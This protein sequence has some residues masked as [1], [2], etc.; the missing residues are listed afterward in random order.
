MK[1]VQKKLADLRPH[2]RNVRRHNQNQVQ[3]LAKAVE[4]FGQ[5][6]PIVCDETGTILCGHGLFEAMKLNGADK[7]DCI[8][9]TG[10]TE[11]QKTKL[12]L[13]D[14]KIYDLGTSDYGVIDEMLR[15]FG[16]EGDFSIPGYDPNVLEDLY[17]I[18]SVEQSA[19]E[20]QSMR[21][22]APPE[23]SVAPPTNTEREPSAQFQ[24]AR[25]AA[26]QRRVV[27]CPNCGGMVEI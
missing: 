5:I 16:Q 25:E 21:P 23:Q 12:M 24:E 19:Q 2:P 11:K 4:T 10:L 6:R 18:R 17:G 20:S 27:I 13:A 9:M 8:V 15:E 26:L 14:N 3:E 22:V 1:T 7:A